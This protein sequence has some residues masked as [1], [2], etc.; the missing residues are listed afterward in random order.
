MLKH[1]GGQNTVVAREFQR[2]LG[3]GTV[4]EIKII[5][6]GGFWEERLLTFSTQGDIEE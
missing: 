3:V 1:L 4:L 6:A 2:Q 5:A